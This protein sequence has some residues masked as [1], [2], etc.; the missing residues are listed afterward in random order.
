MF[1]D[2]FYFF[3]G[4]TKKYTYISNQCLKR[5]IMILRKIDLVFMSCKCLTLIKWGICSMKFWSLLHNSISEN[6]FVLSYQMQNFKITF[7]Y[8][9]SSFSFHSFCHS[10]SRPL[11][12]S[13]YLCSSISPSIYLIFS[14]SLSFSLSFSFFLSHSLSLS[15]PLSSVNPVWNG[16][17]LL[18]NGNELCVYG[19]IL[20]FQSR[21]KAA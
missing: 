14:S 18:C 8:I 3:V 10:L 15:F 20:A 9:H 13:L 12:L 5:V 17:P 2:K 6:I 21:A 1:R 16:S 19:L 4:L 7:H 11:S